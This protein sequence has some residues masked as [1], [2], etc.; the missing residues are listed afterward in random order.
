MFNSNVEKDISGKSKEEEKHIANEQYINL[1][2][3]T[4]EEQKHSIYIYIKRQ[5]TIF[6]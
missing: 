4:R 5:P 2:K 6:R 3:K 1:K